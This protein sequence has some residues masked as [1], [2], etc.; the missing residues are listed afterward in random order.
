MTKTAPLHI[1]PSPELFDNI[2]IDPTNIE[3]PDVIENDIDLKN[4]NKIWT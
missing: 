1:Y 4:V 3:Y 2:L